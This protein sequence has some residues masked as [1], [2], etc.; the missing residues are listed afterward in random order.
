MKQ[1]TVNVSKRGNKQTDDTQNTTEIKLKEMLTRLKKKGL[2]PLQ[3]S[4][5]LTE[6]GIEPPE[7]KSWNYAQVV[8]LCKRLKI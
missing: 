4:E 5:K 6:H 2:N 7:G 3:I 8:A 1:I